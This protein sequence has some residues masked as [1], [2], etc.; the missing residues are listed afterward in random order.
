MN[1][2]VWTVLFIIPVI[3]NV[4]Y[5]SFLGFGGYLQVDR[6]LQVAPVVLVVLSVSKKYK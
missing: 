6:D 4:E 1:L 5:E 2:F 3:I